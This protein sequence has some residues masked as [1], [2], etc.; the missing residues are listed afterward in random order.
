MEAARDYDPA[1]MLDRI[2]ARVLAINSADDE[3]NPP[4]LGVMEEAMKQLKRGR[5]V[6]LPISAESRGHGTTGRAALWKRYLAELLAESHGWTVR[7][8]H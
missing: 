6:L 2:T 1:P 8:L 4:E 7:P 5:Y 3:R